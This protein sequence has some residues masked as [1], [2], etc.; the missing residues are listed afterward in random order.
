MVRCLTPIFDNRGGQFYW[1]KKPA[2]QGKTT[3]KLYHIKLYRVHLI[4]SGIQTRN[5]SDD[6]H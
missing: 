3:D 6:M 5:V 1:W 4:M 2:Y